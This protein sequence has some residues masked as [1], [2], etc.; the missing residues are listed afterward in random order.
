MENVIVI[1]NYTNWISNW[2]EKLNPYF[3]NVNLYIIHIS[4]LQNIDNPEIKKYNSYDVSYYSYFKLK[5]LIQSIA[6]SKCIFFTFRSVLDLT[7]YKLCNELNIKK[8]YLEHGLITN[9]L[10]HFRSNAIKSSPL[11]TIKRQLMHL[12]K[13]YGYALTSKRP[14]IEILFF[15]Q[16]YFKNKFNLFLFDHYLLFS[17]HSIEQL[18]KIFTNVN[19][20]NTIVG[21]PIFTDIQQKNEAKKYI[22]NIE[23]NGIIYVHQPLIFDGVASISYEEEKTYLLHI[24]KILSPHYG[25][26]T[27]LLHPR[28]DIDAYKERFEGEQ[29]KIIKSP[30]NY[31]EFV[32]KNLII[33]HYSTAL[34]YG[35]YFEI[36]TVVLDYPTLKKN[37]LFNSIFPNFSQP[38]Q[39][40]ENDIQINKNMRNYM[41]GN[42]NTY[43]FIAQTIENL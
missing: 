43:Q 23:K 9:D 25:E 2:I 20:N 26:L 36:P 34:L 27:I 16:I 19:Q 4:K 37:N 8:L 21:Y 13:Y 42:T 38:E 7:L 28:S 33:G 17:Q 12:Y 1:L 11:E 24:A 29:I 14:L 18:N 10:L 22:S 30:N 39:I 41:L 31:K 6:P 35:L 3:N 32:D 5:K 40:L 15:I